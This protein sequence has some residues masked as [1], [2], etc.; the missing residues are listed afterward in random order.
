MITTLREAH[1]KHDIIDLLDMGLI[2]ETA[3]GYMDKDEY[4]YLLWEEEQRQAEQELD[5]MAEEFEE[6]QAPL[7]EEQILETV[8]RIKRRVS[9]Q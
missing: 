8:K 3:T 1:T 7:T 2:I 9:G 4:E 6:M 5:E